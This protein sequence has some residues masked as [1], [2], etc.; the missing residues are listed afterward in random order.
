[1]SST[2]SSDPI[3]IQRILSDPPSTPLPY[4]T[5]LLQQ[6]AQVQPQV[7][8]KCLFTCAASTKDYTIAN[9]FAHIIAIRNYMPDFLTSNAEMLSVALMSDPSGSLMKGK[10]I[11]GRAKWAKTRIGQNMVF[12]EVLCKFSEFRNSYGEKEVG[13]IKSCASSRIDVF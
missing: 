4:L 5:T 6:L 10:G 8:Y 1:M 9:E 11:E 3:D 7:F 13:A 12:L 2:F